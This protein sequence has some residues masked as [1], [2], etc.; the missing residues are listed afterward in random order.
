MLPELGAMSPES[1]KT[2][3]VV[4]PDHE[5]KSRWTEFV[6][7]ISIGVAAIGLIINFVF[8]FQS[9][10][11]ED[12]RGQF[13]QEKELMDNKMKDLQDHVTRADKIASEHADDLRRL[14]DEIGELSSRIKS[15]GTILDR[16][17]KY[18]PEAVYK[19]ITVQAN[20]D[21]CKSVMIRDDYDKSHTSP[22]TSICTISK[23]LLQN[24]PENAKIVGAVIANSHY[25]LRL[26]ANRTV[27]SLDI[28]D[29]A[30]SQ[31]VNDRGSEGHAETII[32][33]NDLTRQGGTFFVSRPYEQT[34]WSPH[35]DSHW[36]W[37]GTVL[38]YYISQ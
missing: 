11:K 38:V 36:V 7:P 9:Q 17:T 5:A 2:P 12:V 30:K 3:E 15:A 21:N 16:V 32:T 4:E 19:S 25:N 23:E 34:G 1:A 29:I 24:I 22:F 31:A 18:M 27:G 8:S 6:T 35:S 33:L 14:R 28:F 37:I 10:I 26:T 13:S 20:D